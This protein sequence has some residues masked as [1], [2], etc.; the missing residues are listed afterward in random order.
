MMEGGFDSN[1]SSEVEV[2]LTKKRIN[3]YSYPWN[4]YQGAVVVVWCLN[5]L[6]FF[7]VRLSLSESTATKIGLIVTFT[8]LCGIMVVSGHICASTNAEDYLVR[9]Q[10]EKGKFVNT[11]YM[12]KI[13]QAYVETGTKHCKKCNKCVSGFD[14]HCKWLN[15]CIG[16]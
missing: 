4:A 10:L 8:S 5:I 7:L 16:S 11:E 1:K 15:N 14:H 3:G 12:C 6:T 2:I 9:E 13:C